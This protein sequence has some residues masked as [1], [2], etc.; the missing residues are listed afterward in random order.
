M[1]SLGFIAAEGVE[2]VYMAAALFFVLGLKRL[3]RVKTARVGNLFASLAMLL[4]VGATV[5]LLAGVHWWLLVA[6]CSLAPR[7]GSCSRPASR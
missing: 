1:T 7:S 2:L 6:V 5:F 4:A 3:S